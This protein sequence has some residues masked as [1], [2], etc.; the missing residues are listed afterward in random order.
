[1]ARTIKQQGREFRQR[2]LEDGKVWVSVQDGGVTRD[3]YLGVLFGL[4]TLYEH[5]AEDYEDIGSAVKR[6]LAL[7][8]DFM[9][10]NNWLLS[11]DET[12]T[13]IPNFWSPGSDQ[14]YAYLAVNNFV[15]GGKYQAQ[16]NEIRQG[17]P[18]VWLEA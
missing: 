15:T 3:Q 2:K 1:M 7:Q 4:A 5:A 9:M 12:K 17:A 6:L 16:L 10:R 14:K 8:F 11:G 13:G 18:A